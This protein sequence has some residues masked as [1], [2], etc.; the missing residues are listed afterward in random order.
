[1]TVGLDTLGSDGCRA[2]IE[3]AQPQH[4]SLIDRTHQLAHKFGVNNIPSSIWID[5]SYTIVRPAEAAP[6]PPKEKPKVSV[7]LPEEAPQRLKDMM[8]EAAKITSDAAAYHAAL[9]DWVKKGSDSTF[10]LSPEEVVARSR[11]RDASVARGHAHF[12]LAAELERRGRHD[13]AVAHFKQAHRL[14]PDSWTFRRQAWSLEPMGE[15]PLSRFWQGPLP[16]HPEDWPYQGD[17]LTD[18]K[19]VG[20]ENYVEPWKP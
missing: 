6:A 8:G 12:E 18:I 13:L 19:K 16:D 5:E 17:W 15:G 7:V 1:M 20:A 14:V 3:A 11:P 10:S 9:H 2:F 4:P